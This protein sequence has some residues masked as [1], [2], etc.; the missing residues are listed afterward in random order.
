LASSQQRRE[1]RRIVQVDLAPSAAACSG[2]GGG[3]TPRGQRALPPYSVSVQAAV[4]KAA[5]ASQPRQPP[6]QLPSSPSSSSAGSARSARSARSPEDLCA[7]P[8]RGSLLR[9]KPRGGSGGAGGG[10]EDPGELSEGGTFRFHQWRIDA[11]GIQAMPALPLAGSG[12]R[13]GHAPLPLSGRRGSSESRGGGSRGRS[14]QSTSRAAHATTLSGR[15]TP[16]SAR[17]PLGGFSVSH[18]GG[19]P[20]GS[21]GRAGG[22]ATPR[23]PSSPS[24]PHR[25]PSGSGLASSSSSSS[26]LLLPAV[27]SGSGPVVRGGAAAQP[28]SPEPRQRRSS[29]DGF[30]TDESRSEPEANADGSGGS[31]SGD[32]DSNLGASRRVASDALLV[33]ALRLDGPRASSG[34]ALRDVLLATPRHTRLHLVRRAPLLC[35]DSLFFLRY[36]SLSLSLLFSFLSFSCFFCKRNTSAYPFF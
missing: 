4:A 35:V 10:E 23:T 17:P 31:D 8:W 16:H 11:D 15:R 21:G 7:V 20:L 6:R 19:T 22:G 12:G 5:A 18:G 24:T 29:A 14:S 1:R 32:E 30:D 2:A 28:W 25:R 27:P 33:Q 36:L 26:L 34:A 13:Y 9:V 3:Q